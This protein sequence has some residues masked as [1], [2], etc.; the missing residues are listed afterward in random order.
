VTADRQVRSTRVLALL[1]CLAGAIAIVL[2]WNA[3]AER[4][5]VTSQL[6]YVLSGGAAGIG[7]LTFGVG[8]LLVAQLRA[9]RR[10]VTGVLQLM[11][12]GVVSR[13]RASLAGAAS[14]EGDGTA[15]AADEAEGDGK[16]APADRPGGER[17]GL[18]MRSAKVVALVL[19][20]A[21]FATIALGWSGMTNASTADQQLP[22]LLSGGFGGMALIVSA[23]GLLLVAQIRAERRKLTDVLAVM[24]VAVG[25]AAS[26]GPATAHGAP[27]AGE[28]PAQH[29]A[30][31]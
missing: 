29:A 22:Y 10:R 3:A 26:P 20:V 5:S 6:P 28:P 9:E 19:A 31:S 23:M 16:A 4:A 7:L 21:G 12:A 18:A 15:P 2:G 27:I 11:G 24:A 8:L 25:Q 13:A 1:F 30:A 17:A 14:G